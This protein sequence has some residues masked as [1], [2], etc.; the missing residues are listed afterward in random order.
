MN[1]PTTKWKLGWTVAIVVTSLLLGYIY[2]LNQRHEKALEDNERLQEA[3]DSQTETL[4]KLSSDND[5]LNEQVQ[6]IHSE[7]EQV[8]KVNAELHSSYE[9]LKSTNSN[10]KNQVE[11]Y[12]KTNSTLSETLR[13]LKLEMNKS[14][15]ARNTSSN[16]NISVSRGKSVKGTTF[17][18][19]AT[20]YTAYCKGCSG[21][22]ATGINLRENSNLKV[23]AVD[24]SI[25]PL[26]TKVYVEGYGYA[27]AGDT[28][29][30]IKGYK[31]DLFMSSKSDAYDWGRRT[32]P[33][34]ILE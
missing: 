30:A 3:Y 12:K 7:M 22:T 25:I 27:I 29:G 20:A 2:S 9:E 5:K 26:G 8:L 24:P 6:Q 28:G 33:I 21:I 10:L 34:T 15:S 14:A 19:V 32:V 18:V 23:I 31:V 17:N 11:E 1:L 4:D 13:K 16:M